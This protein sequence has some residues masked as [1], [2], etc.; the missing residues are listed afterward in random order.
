MHITLIAGARPNFVKISPIIHAIDAHNKAC[1]KLIDYALVHT[2]Q[3]YDRKMST[4][5]F[6]DLNIPE[7]KINLNVGSS[8]HAEQTAKIMI[9][10]EKYLNANPT[11]CV[12]VVGDVNS[13]MACAIVA[14]KMN[15]KVAHVEG[16][17]RSGDI[18]MP[19]EIN[20]LLTDS[21]S[22]YYFTTSDFANS[23][24]KREGV[25]DKRIFL[26]GNTMIDSLVESL[27]RLK[28]PKEIEG[29]D[30]T[31]Y[32]LLTLHRPSNVDSAEQLSMI[33]NEIERLTDGWRVIFPI[34]PR[35]K[36]KLMDSDRFKNI[37]FIEPL[38]YLEFLYLMKGANAVITDSGGIQEETTFLK[39]PCLTLRE[40]TERP[41]TIEIG[42]NVLIGNNMDLL[43]SNLNSIREGKWKESSI[44][45]LWDG[46]ASKRIIENLVNLF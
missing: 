10:F 21:I 45:P 23:N 11:D 30:I 17:L 26:V 18:S 1:E 41:E 40:N 32:F 3:H 5:F 31:N 15:V 27:S 28:I 35:T 7:P 22:D 20:R 42:S 6:E 44:P 19:E 25:S 2:G 16:G 46:N 39:V 37:H 12:L 4:S 34:H 43:R 24:L 9:E 33:L 14:K 8:S 29:L 38:P 36:S 13:T